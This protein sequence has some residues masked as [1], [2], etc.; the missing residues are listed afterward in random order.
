MERV[1]TGIDGLDIM[2]KGGL[3]P[4]RVYLIK[5]GP[6]TGKSTLA[7]HF[8]MEGVKSGERVL[9]ITLEE[10]VKTLKE[11]M[12][13]LG[14]DVDDP[15]FTLVEAT[16]VGTKR[17]IFDNVHYDEFA[18]D[19]SR[20]LKKIEEKFANGN[21]KRAVVDPITMLRLTLPEELE[22]RRSVITLVKEAIRSGVTLLLIAETTNLELED[23][24]V[25]GVIEMKKAYVTGKPMRT[26]E[27]VK[28]RGSSFDESPRP[29]EITERGIVVYNTE[30]IMI[31]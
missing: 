18:K 11:D 20:F 31:E 15:L 14:F 12:G 6:G 27:I 21:F 9:Y 28:F 10:P 3:L 30:S 17:S 1:S 22:Y 16:P 19:F 4:G 25:H 26:I 29:Y 5:G 8:A 7:M 24:L 2:L 13:K 23:Y